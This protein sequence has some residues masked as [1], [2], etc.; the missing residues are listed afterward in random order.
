MT[1]A[2]L[3]LSGRVLRYTEIEQTGP[4]VRLLRLGN[5]DFEFDAEA[6]LFSAEPPSRLDILTDALADVFENSTATVFRFAVPPSHL[7]SF[8]ALVPVESDSTV[9]SDLIASEASVL[10]VPMDGDLF[11]SPGSAAGRSGVRMHVARAPRIIR[12]RV[13]DLCDGIPSPT[14]TSKDVQEDARSRTGGS[15]HV[16]LVPSSS[17]V[18]HLHVHLNGDSGGTVLLVGCYPGSTEYTVLDG[19]EA[20]LEWTDDMHHPVD[21]LYFCLDVLDRASVTVPAVAAVHLYGPNA[22]DE[23]R[24]VLT[25]VFGGRVGRLD[26]CPAVNVSPDQFDAD[27]RFESYAACIGAALS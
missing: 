11:P 27:F 21:R 5:C 8:S 23:V 26:P 22:D 17:A 12:D 20:A 3:E 7:T 15:R 9:R 14:G 13:V 4:T 1:T 16:G 2:G 18:R 19:G 10:G 24:D 25:P 6:D